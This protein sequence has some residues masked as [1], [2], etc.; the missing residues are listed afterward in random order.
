MAEE[1]KQKTEKAAEEM[2]KLNLGKLENVA[3]GAEDPLRWEEDEKGHDNWC[4][5]AWHC[6]T[7]M[8][9]TESESRWVSCWSD[10]NCKIFNK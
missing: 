8:L 5:A 3:G 4:V 2:E 10:Y 6:Y 7:A 9:H 1:C